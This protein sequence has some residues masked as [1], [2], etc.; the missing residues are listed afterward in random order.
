MNLCNHVP[1]VLQK[2]FEGTFAISLRR[3]LWTHTKIWCHK[4]GK[5]LVYFSCST[6]KVYIQ[7]TFYLI[8]LNIVV[9]LL[10]FAHLFTCVHSLCPSYFFNF[11]DNGNYTNCVFINYLQMDTYK[12]KMNVCV[13]EL[14]KHLTWIQ[15]S[16]SI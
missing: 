2:C 3:D 8:M 15:G 9:E 12:W 6:W 10:R 7:G 14:A 16:R 5:G 11:W 1:K 4:I 13:K